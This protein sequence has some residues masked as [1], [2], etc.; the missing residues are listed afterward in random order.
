MVN[1]IIFISLIASQFHKIRILRM[2]FVS[3]QNLPPESVKIQIVSVLL[4]SMFFRS[5]ASERWLRLWAGSHAFYTPC[6][7]LERPRLQRWRPWSWSKIKPP[8]TWCRISVVVCS[9]TTSMLW[10]SLAYHGVNFS[11]E[12]L[13]RISCWRMWSLQV[14]RFV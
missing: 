9:P 13:E 4:Y 2:A 5:F 10:S 7:R 1:I 12:V 3:F 14:S 11:H 6:G 8:S